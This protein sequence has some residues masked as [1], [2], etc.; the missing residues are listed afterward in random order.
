MVYIL[1]ILDS[2]L[3]YG[4]YLKG[5]YYRWVGRGSVFLWIFN[6]LLDVGLLGDGIVMEFMDRV[7]EMILRFF[8]FRF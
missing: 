3:D 6:C 5:S 7:G 1:F 2:G 8:I 4:I